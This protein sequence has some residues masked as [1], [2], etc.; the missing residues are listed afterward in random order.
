M[1]FFLFCPIFQHFPI[2]KYDSSL[3]FSYL[4]I[5]ILILA[6]P[7]NAN[8]S[9]TGEYKGD[10]FGDLKSQ[11]LTL[12]FVRTLKSLSLVSLIPSPTSNLTDEDDDFQK[13]KGLIHGNVIP[14]PTPRSAVFP[15]HCFAFPSYHSQNF[16]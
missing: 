8:E 4:S 5:E 9:L 12:T 16:V 15:L 10:D 11:Q 7:S 14:L 2:K 3:L 1:T 6:Q 13:G